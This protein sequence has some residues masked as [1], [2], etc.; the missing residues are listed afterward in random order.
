M[1]RTLRCTVVL[2]LLMASTACSARRTASAPPTAY[3]RQGIIAEIKDFQK[4]LG[5]QETE[6]FLRYS[7]ATRAYYRCYYTGKLE[8]P[9]SYEHLQLTQGAVQGCSLDEKQYDIFFYPIEA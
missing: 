2:T 3:P 4:T 7:E 5:F 9:P 8:L 1:S 6:N